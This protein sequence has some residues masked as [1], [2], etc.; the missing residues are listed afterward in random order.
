MPQWCE[1][2]KN[3]TVND[4]HLWP[5]FLIFTVLKACKRIL[6]KKPFEDKLKELG[7]KKLFLC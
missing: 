7:T 6:A 1:N 2:E 3:G 4:R 5:P